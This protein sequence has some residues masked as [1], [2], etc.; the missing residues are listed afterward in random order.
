MKIIITA[1]EERTLWAA[2]L[3]EAE[4]AMH[5]LR[6]GTKVVAVDMPDD[7]VQFQMANRHELERYIT[8]I[9]TALGIV[10]EPKRPRGRRMLYV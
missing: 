10:A 3:V 8:D 5:K 2:R 6:T 9:R 1:E 7:K 4:T